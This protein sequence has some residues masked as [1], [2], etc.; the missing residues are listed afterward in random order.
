MR[1]LAA[2]LLLVAVPAQ[3]EVPDIDRRVAN[4]HWMLK[5]LDAVKAG[6]AG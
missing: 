6:W 1:A 2:G 5:D 4:V 3:A